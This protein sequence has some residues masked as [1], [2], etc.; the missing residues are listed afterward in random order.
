MKRFFWQVKGSSREHK[1]RLEWG[2]S[3]SRAQ[4][5]RPEEVDSSRIEEVDSFWIVERRLKDWD[6]Q[7][8]KGEAESGHL[9]KSGSNKGGAMDF[10]SSVGLA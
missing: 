3:I 2:I 1:A 6:E 8:A 7:G 10:A 9:G 4:G 5:T